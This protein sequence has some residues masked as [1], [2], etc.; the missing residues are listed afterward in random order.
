MTVSLNKC[1]LPTCSAI[2]SMLGVK[3]FVAN[4]VGPTL[5]LTVTTSVH[6]CLSVF[7]IPNASTCTPCHTRAALWQ[8]PTGGEITLTCVLDVGS[9]SFPSVRKL[10]SPIV[11]AG[12]IMPL[13]PVTCSSYVR[14]FFHLPCK[15]LELELLTCASRTHGDQDT[16]LS[17][18]DLVGKR[19]AP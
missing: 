18:R 2:S 6:A 15:A 7:P 12:V 5:S 4:A 1:L 10:R 9:Q 14:W 19:K 8:C 3:D 13:L 16:V 11:T 17:F